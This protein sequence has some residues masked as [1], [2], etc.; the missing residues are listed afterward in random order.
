ML[1]DFLTYQ[2]QTSP[3][4]LGLEVSHAKG[5]YIFDTSGKAHLDF[6]AGVSACSLGHCHPVVVNA[7][8]E[9][10]DK[11]AHVMVYGEYAQQPAVALSKLLATHL[12]PSLNTTYLVNSGTEAI[13]ASLKLARKATGRTE[14]LFA[15]NAY[16]GNT[17]GSM[18]VM[19]YEDRKKPFEPLIPDCHPIEFNNEAHLERITSKTAA[20]ILETIQGGAGFILPKDNYLQKVKQRCEEVGAL[21]ILDEIQPGFGRT[22]KLFGFQN[23]DVVPDILVMGKGM[24]GGLPIGAF[25]ASNE[26]M[27]HLKDNP[28]LGHITT[29]GGNPVIAAAALATLKEITETSLM[30]DALAKENTFRKLLK[31]PLI[32]EV[33]GKGLMLVVMVESAE[34]ASEIILACKERGLI[35]FWLLFEGKAIRITPP[36]TISEE[37]I[38][39]GCAILT[40]VLNTINTKK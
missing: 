7:V 25:T 40:E 5:S 30:K 8:K 4:P 37:E 15:H 14:I 28:K 10:M 20:V 6:V 13:E 38:E 2:A 17:M 36:L 19:D 23:Y 12:P 11:Y 26:L 21:L 34:M 1:K 31:H 39:K 33:R 22:G 18:S 3:H 32:K 29:F 24:G 27:S 16:H 9:Q 35:L